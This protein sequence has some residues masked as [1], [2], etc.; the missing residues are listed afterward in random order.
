MT[1]VADLLRRSHAQHH[2]AQAARKVKNHAGHLL[3]CSEALDLRLSAHALD[4]DHA[5]PAWAAEVLKKFRHDAL[6]AF[7]AHELGIQD[8]DPIVMTREDV[9]AR[10]GGTAPRDESLAF[11][12]LCQ[13]RGITP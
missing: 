12:Q 2:Q 9:L 8:V 10:V 1:D 7:Y 5:D 11:T 4:P 13:E 3:C 6:I